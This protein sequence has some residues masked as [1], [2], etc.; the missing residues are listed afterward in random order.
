ME[1]LPHHYR[2][3]V[4]LQATAD[5]IPLRS[6]GLP[7]LTT[8][9]PAEYGGPGDRWSPETLLVG[10]VADCYA[11]TFRAIARASKLEWHKLTCAVEGT[12]EKVDRTVR[13][14]EITIDAALEAPAGSESRAERILHKAEETCLVTAS[15]SAT[16]TLNATVTVV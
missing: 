14:T 11:L 3:T 8:N 12:L 5:D 16:V 2:A 7:E 13:F 4:D 9:A 6:P 1:P 10:T 15:L